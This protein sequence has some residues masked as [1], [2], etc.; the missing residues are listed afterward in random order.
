MGSPAP[1]SG[2]RAGVTAVECHAVWLLATHVHIE[3][4][5][6]VTDTHTE[7]AAASTL[8]RVCQATQPLPAPAPQGDGRLAPHGAIG[9]PLRLA[10]AGGSWP[11]FQV[12]V[13]GHSCRPVGSPC[14]WVSL[15]RGLC[16][17]RLDASEAAR[18]APRG[19]HG[20]HPSPESGFLGGG[21][22][23]NP[24]G[25]GAGGQKRLL[26]GVR[27]V[28]EGPIPRGPSE[29]GASPQ[30]QASPLASR[31]GGLRAS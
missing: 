27:W 31:H 16:A 21:G 28:G 26:R 7:T 17:S 14:A 30:A 10:G 15:S 23:R 1:D 13:Q 25:L 6:L 19:A 5:G 2:P 20:R 11:A 24:F 3:G 8:P 12:W 18:W 9:V 22:R 29:N 4:G